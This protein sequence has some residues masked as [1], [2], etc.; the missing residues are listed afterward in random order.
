MVI[1]SGLAAKGVGFV[2]LQEYYLYLSEREFGIQS[3]VITP[4]K[5]W[6]ENQS[7]VMEVRTLNQHI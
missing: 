1:V 2:I 5:S 7:V 6:F 3:V 4:T